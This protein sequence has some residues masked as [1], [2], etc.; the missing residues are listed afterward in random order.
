MWGYRC[1]GRTGNV[2]LSGCLQPCPAASEAAFFRRGAKAGPRPALPHTPPAYLPCHLSASVP[3]PGASPRGR[4][5]AE[6][7][8]VHGKLSCLMINDLDAGIGHFENTQVGEGWRQGGGRW[9]AGWQEVGGP[10]RRA[11]RP[12]SVAR[13]GRRWPV[14]LD[15][16]SRLPSG[17]S[18]PDPLT[19]ATT[20]P[21]TSP[22]HHPHPPP[23]PTTAALCRSR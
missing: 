19:A 12:G 2:G 17:P 14:A 4:R 5:A 13:P 21:H 1:Q 6:V 9:A 22:H 18:L 10:G 15:D 16:A 7:S 23:T 20:S 8:K 11:C 3:L